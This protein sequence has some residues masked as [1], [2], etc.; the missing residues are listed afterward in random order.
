MM[1]TL[2]SQEEAPGDTNYKIADV[3]DHTDPNTT[4]SNESAS[5]PSDS[6]YSQDFHRGKAN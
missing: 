3:G 1:N 6:D 4:S 5:E 2:G